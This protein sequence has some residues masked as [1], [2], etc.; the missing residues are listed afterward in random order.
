MTTIHTLSSTEI[1][2]NPNSN[3]N[4]RLNFIDYLSSLDEFD[5]YAKTLT[6]NNETYGKPYK[7]DLTNFERGI[8]LIQVLDIN[9][10]NF[11]TKL[12]R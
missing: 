9:G 2:F 4:N 6:K 7:L 8:Y 1:R 10:N 11:A 5:T 12:V 3:S